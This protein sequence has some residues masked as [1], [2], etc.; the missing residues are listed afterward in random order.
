MPAT[1]TKPV[2]VDPQAAAS[3]LLASFEN[4]QQR[5]REV[6]LQFDEAITS[7]DHVMS[8]TELAARRIIGYDVDTPEGRKEIIAKA[9][10]VKAHKQTAGSS[11]DF[12]AAKQAA[13]KAASS[14]AARIEQLRESIATAELELNSIA[15]FSDSGNYIGPLP[16]DA[17]KRVKAMTNARDE[18]RKPHNLPPYV[19]QQWRDSGTV[20]C[21]HT[22]SLRNKLSRLK[23]EVFRIESIA[24]ADPRENQETILQYAKHKGINIRVERPNTPDQTIYLDEA[25]TSH[26]NELKARRNELLPEIAAVEKQ[27]ADEHCETESVLD[28]HI[29]QLG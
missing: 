11:K 4:E 1:A 20:E 8:A 18:L 12:E 26:T 17:E 15:R 5:Y 13:D 23:S 25:W 6:D 2:K 29:K 27:L 7:A 16:T 24:F 14:R 28:F 21:H 10:R 19:Q 3:T 22:Q 9:L